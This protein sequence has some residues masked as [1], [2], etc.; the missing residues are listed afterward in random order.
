MAMA[1]GPQ[2]IPTEPGSM[3]MALLDLVHT[4][5]FV[6]SVFSLGA[7]AMSAIQRS[8]VQGGF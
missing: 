7:G 5:S 6:F 8:G 3:A 2:S 4:S 1:W